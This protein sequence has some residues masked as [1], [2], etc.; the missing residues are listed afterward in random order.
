MRCVRSI[1]SGGAAIAVGLLLFARPGRADES[2]FC[3][4]VRAQAE[5]D[6]ALL[7]APRLVVQGI[8]FPAGN[9]LGIG[10]T[11]GTGYQVR[12]GIVFSLLDFYKG[13]KLGQLADAQCSV[14]EVS[15][16][17]ERVLETAGDA[18][19]L[20]AVRAEAA[21]LNENRGRWLAMTSRAAER[22]AARVTTVVEFDQ[23]RSHADALERR[24]VEVVGETRRLEARD[25]VAPRQPLQALVER[26]N[27]GT[28]QV[29]RQAWSLHS[30]DGWQ[31]QL[32]AGL[33][34]IE[35]VDWYGVAELSYSLG[36]VARDRAATRYLE[37][38][39]DEVH[40]APEEIPFKVR[41][42]ADDVAAALEQARREL[43]IVEAQVS[44]MTAAQIALERSETPDSAQGHDTLAM[45]LI[46]AEAD[47]VFLR[48]SV[49]ALSRLSENLRER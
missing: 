12:T 40:E 25:I 13:T 8:R 19:R 42:L 31:F 6:R 10:A 47:Q 26:H 44:A 48:A 3:R 38:R 41:K 11:A 16:G 35:P 46:A 21:Y 49:E 33:I 7:M 37:A 28:M 34:P 1:R 5:G 24:R 20:E 30:L 22:L 9:Q 17:L 23:L 18:A 39:H 45:E 27:R 15:A 4:K 14:H 2:A 29:E 36:S 43:E 32:T